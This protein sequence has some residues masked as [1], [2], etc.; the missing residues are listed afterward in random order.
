VL[1]SMTPTGSSGVRFGQFFI[2]AVRKIHLGDQWT[3]LDLDLHHRYL[4]LDS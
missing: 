4:N 3:H 2:P 1:S